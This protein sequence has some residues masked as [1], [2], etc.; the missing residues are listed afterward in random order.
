MLHR[1]RPAPIIGTIFTG[2][3]VPDRDI[4]ARVLLIKRNLCH[5]RAAGICL[6][7]FAFSKLETSCVIYA[8]FMRLKIERGMRRSMSQARAAGC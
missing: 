6:G 7:A 8:V 3:M 1:E 4:E 5:L 2:L